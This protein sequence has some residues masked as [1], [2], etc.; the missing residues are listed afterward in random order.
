[1]KRIAP[2]GEAA[3]GVKGISPV[4]YISPH[5]VA[6]E[7]GSKNITKRNGTNEDVKS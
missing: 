2:L 3:F 6:L 7:V 5:A 1:M 4:Q